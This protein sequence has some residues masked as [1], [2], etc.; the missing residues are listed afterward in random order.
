MDNYK[1]N[2]RV[3]KN[4]DTEEVIKRTKVEKVI[5]GVVKSKKKNGLLSMF[6][7]EEV[8]DIKSH[9]IFEVLIPAA[10]KAVSDGVNMMLFGE[11]GN[12][13]KS[14]TSSKVSYREY[15]GREEREV[16]RG[17]DRGRSRAGGYSYDDIILE[18]RAEANDV[19]SRLDE[20]IDVYGMASVADLYDLVGITGQ[21]TDNNYGWKDI[22]SASHVSV[23]DGYLLKLP[24]ARPL[25]LN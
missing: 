8:T 23:R 4:K 22:G 11:T 1:P 7:P 3:S 14:A 24:I 21:Y 6:M 20:I 10:K 17:R 25:N 16:E 18:S 9:I 13:R 5:T 2:S 12:S 19:I 15:Y